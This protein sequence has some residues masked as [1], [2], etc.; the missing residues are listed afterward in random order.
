M[1]KSC[2]QRLPGKWDVANCNDRKRERRILKGKLLKVQFKHHVDSE[3][4]PDVPEMRF[5]EQCRLKREVQ[6]FA[7]SSSEEEDQVSD[8]EDVLPLAR[9]QKKRLAQEAKPV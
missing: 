6:D 9:L 8:A 1:G 5:S 7:E 2:Q 3:C 4:N